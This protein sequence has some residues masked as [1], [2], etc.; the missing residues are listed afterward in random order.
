MKQ[1]Q[2]KHLLGLLHQELAST[3]AV[4]DE[5]KSLLEKLNDDIQHVLATTQ[6]QDDPV[7]AALSER[8]QALSAKFAAQHPKLEPALRELGTM[9]EKIG[10]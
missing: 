3:E 7:F 5:L 10:V 1:E 9:L 8:S 2:L 4:D 6:N